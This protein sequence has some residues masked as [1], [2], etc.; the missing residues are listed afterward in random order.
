MGVSSSLLT[1]SQHDGTSPWHV[2]AKILEVVGA[3]DRLMR[4]VAER[5]SK[6]H[7]LGRNAAHEVFCFAPKFSRSRVLVQRG[8]GI[9][10]RTI[11]ARLIGEEPH[12]RLGLA[13]ILLEA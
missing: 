7:P 6:R 5:A 9:D 2:V 4:Y 10:R 13:L 8:I 1:D 11:V 3:M 12:P